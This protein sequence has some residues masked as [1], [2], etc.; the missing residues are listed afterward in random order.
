MGGSYKASVERSLEYLSQELSTLDGAIE[1]LI[2]ES[3]DLAE[4]QQLLTSC[5]GVGDKTAWSLLGLL[6]ELGQLNRK[7]VGALAGLAP[8][9]QQSGQWQGKACIRG[10]RSAVRK[11]LY[12]AALSTTRYCPPIAK[13]Y[14]HLTQQGKA[15]KVAL[16]ACMHKLLRI[17]NQMLATNS[18]FRLDA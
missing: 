1:T 6:P 11:A 3:P 18:P 9:Q 2:A 16:V 15:K 7:A 13:F 8:F 4:K 5:P 10:G 14:Q 12:M 17:L